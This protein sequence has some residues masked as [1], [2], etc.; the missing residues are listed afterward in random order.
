M[1]GPSNSA[2]FAQQRTD[3]VLRSHPRSAIRFGTQIQLSGFGL[4]VLW[5]LAPA[6]D[7]LFLPLRRELKGEGVHVL[8]AYPGATD[9]P[10]MRSNRAGPELGFS[11]EPASAVADAIVEG[12]ETGAF[13]VIL[14]PPD[15]SAVFLR[16]DSQ[17]AAL[18]MDAGSRLKRVSSLNAS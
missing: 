9:T 17:V 8:T 6:L 3:S 10:M 1:A 5:C 4:H 11:R 7:F 14:P 13:E 2:G 18:G 12:I 16:N 15:N